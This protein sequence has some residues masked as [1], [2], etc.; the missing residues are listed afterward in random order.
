MSI[1]MLAKYF[2][3]YLYTVYSSSQYIGIHIFLEFLSIFIAFAAFTMVWLLKDGLEGPSGL[4]LITLGTSFMAVGGIDLFHTL[5]FNGMPLFITPSS[6]Q[7]ATFLWLLGRYTVAA[8]FIAAFIVMRSKLFSLSGSLLSGSLLAANFIV[9]AVA[10]MLSTCCLELIPPLFVEGSGLTAL[11]IHLEYGVI[12]LYILVFVILY[13]HRTYFKDSIFENLVC[14]IIITIVSEIAFTFYK[15]VYDTYNLIGHLYKICAY[16]FLF[17][18]IHL[19]GIVNHFYVLSEMGKMSAQLLADRGTI[20]TL[21]EIQMDKLKQLIPQAERIVV[22]AK[23][24]DDHYQA[25]FVWG[26]FSKLLPS[27][28]TIFFQ[29]IF[30]F[31]GPKIELYNKPQELIAKL[32]PGDYT[33]GIALVWK[34]ATQM[35]YIPLIAEEYF[36]GFILLYSF[37]HFHRFSEGDMEKAV[38]FQKFAILAIAQVKY[39]ETIFRLS[40]EDGLTQL[41]NR[42]YFF[43]QITEAQYETARYGIPFTVI[44][45]D[46]NDLKHINDIYGHAAGDAALRIIGQKL[47]NLVRKTDIV[48]RLG[49]D[50]F[51]IILKH[52]PLEEGRKKIA[53]LQE[54]FSCIELPDYHT[55]F[56]LATGGTT[57]PTEA[58]TQEMLLRLADDR[59]YEHKRSMKEARNRATP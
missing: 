3:P 43:E 17:K 52:A 37:R 42:R 46:M 56:S 29:N 1:L 44:F 47:K 39:R 19:S 13:K 30:Q 18:A 58:R 16:F 5:S 26:K 2:T 10:L 53:E 15:S 49:G 57:Y 41:P 40:Y 25:A 8:G 33:P 38:V 59:M 12:L 45:F 27:H 31:L 32:N 11:K 6:C 28:N 36:Y 54:Y 4:F 24:A 23:E 21:L 14:F 7:K 20:N 34:E 48:A 35:L 9:I 51:G 55:S 22:Y 50:E